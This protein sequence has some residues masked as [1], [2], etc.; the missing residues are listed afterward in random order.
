MGVSVRC[1]AV[2]LAAV[3]AFAGVAIA[4]DS[5]YSAREIQQELVNRGH[6]PG[7][8]DGVWG[9]RST[10]A[11]KAFQKAEGLPQSGALDK[12]TAE[13]LFPLRAA[14]R[15][16]L[17][18][19]PEKDM[20]SPAAGEEV[21]IQ[22]FPFLNE[23]SGAAVTLLRL[24]ITGIGD[25]KLL[26][27]DSAGIRE[28][29]RRQIGA[30]DLGMV[31]MRI[32]AAGT[33]ADDSFLPP[34]ARFSVRPCEDW[35]A[36]AKA[37]G[38][39]SASPAEAIVEGEAR[40]PEPAST[41]REMPDDA[42]PPPAVS[43]AASGTLSPLI[44]LVLPVFAIVLFLRRRRCRKSMPAKDRAVAAVADTGAER[45]TG[46]WGEASPTVVYD[47][48]A[49]TVDASSS[50]RR[51]IPA[52]G[53]AAPS[54]PMGWVPAHTP[55]AIGSHRIARGMIYVG[56]HLPRR[57]GSRE[58][59]NCLIDPSLPVAAR[60]DPGG[61][62]MGYWPSYSR[63]SP[64][65]RKTY[66]DWL[67]GPRSDPKT[68]IG[69]VFLYLY[70]LERRLMLEEKAADAPAVAAEVR[71]LLA[72]Y[73]SNGSMRR[74]AGELLSAYRAK[75]MDFPDGFIP[76]GD[77]EGYDVPLSLTVAFGIRMDRHQPV[78]PD[79]LLAYVM[80]HPETRVRTPARRALAMLK[81]L[82][83]DAVREHYPKGLVVSGAR[84]RRL[85]ARYRAASGTFE[86]EVLP[87]GGT[88]PD[89][90]QLVEPLA[91]G[92]RILDA[93][94]DRLDAYSRELGRTEGA[95]PTL[96][97]IAKLPAG[98]R[99]REAE[100]LAG[101]PLDAIEKLAAA[102]IVVTLR[103]LLS[104]AGLDSGDVP[105]RARLK[106]FSSMLA[107]FGYG[108]T[109]DPAFSLKTAKPDDRVAVFRLE[110]E[111][112]EAP[113]PGEQYRA[114]QLSIML[115]LTVALAD[116]EMHA[117][118]QSRLGEMIEAAPGISGEERARLKAELVVQ[119][120]DPQRL[121]DWA[122]RIK[123]APEA[124]RRQLADALVGMATADGALDA[125]EVSYLE[126]LFKP[127]GMEGDALYSRLHGGLAAG[128]RDEDLAIVIPAGNDRGVPIPQK[129]RA[130]RVDLGR[131]D[132]IRRETRTT[133]SVL[134]E[135][136][137]DEEETVAEPAPPV[138][139]AD[140]FSDGFDGLERRYGALVSELR[141][142]AEW[143]AA[144]FDRLVRE[145]GL[146]PGAAKETLNDWS[147][148]RFDELLLEG[149]DP[150]HVNT[151]VLPPPI[152]PARVERV[153]A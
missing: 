69:Y 107:A 80:A 23:E 103:Q 41:D 2:F 36:L 50:P 18:K 81:V 140:A 125:R 128:E 131:L 94:T 93:C 42:M 148:D 21:A 70:G 101:R 25:C 19:T 9:R 29:L 6:D 26:A 133:A 1:L 24:A 39:L 55:V 12:P 40:Q 63:I 60:G 79:L 71:R 95:A 143:P 48:K 74:Y 90:T 123:D 82:F 134:A 147:L 151:H 17:L 66:L 124:S 61:E 5:S 105:S 114:V 85:K 64:A 15:E 152:L 51:T 46:P 22:P 14:I 13:K 33:A 92:Q 73:G 116:G 87:A 136:F 77:G 16:R 76:E 119:Q 108:N 38:F 57:D 54:A 146:M 112:A 109:A 34:L 20:A 139:E 127:M 106:E 135:I 111:A 43:G 58:N 45:T 59:E 145:A 62:S 121:A 91:T 72:I 3:L 32:G 110:G 53:T 150:I 141:E 97:A 31:E 10:N 75:A 27:L 117:L 47:V 137:A 144:E 28:T 149:E 86:V 30:T 35:S 84:V 138:R 126:K 44:Y 83:A 153:E 129:P 4:Q 99:R 115:G 8:V 65:A 100:A 118:E 130:S 122:R 142:R 68:P 96:A 37:R 89:I 52:S 7:A 88:L 11:L 56:G 67:A 49:R 98:Y 78:E 104:Q 102:G 132:A 120:A 113:T